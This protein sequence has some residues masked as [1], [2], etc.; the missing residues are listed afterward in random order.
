M[1][2]REEE[3]SMWRIVCCDTERGRREG[4]ESGREDDDWIE[5]DGVN[6]RRVRVIITLIS[7]P[8]ILS[9]RH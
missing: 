3:L 7:N 5:R 1:E 8:I 2:G 4:D 6:D 9:H